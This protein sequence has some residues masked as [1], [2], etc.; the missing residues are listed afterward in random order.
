MLYSIYHA[1][2]QMA[3]PVCGAK[4]VS[5][6]SFSPFT[7][8]SS[9]V[10]SVPS[11]LSVFHFSRKVSP[12]TNISWLRGSIIR[13]SWLA[14]LYHQWDFIYNQ[15]LL[16]SNSYRQGRISYRQN[17]I[18]FLKFSSSVNITYKFCT[19]KFHTAVCLNGMP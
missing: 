7:S 15:F 10:I 16:T 14:P 4:W 9:I 3:Y 2:K 8:W 5:N 6:E 18:F 13:N 12:V 17:M 19:I 11:V 1:S